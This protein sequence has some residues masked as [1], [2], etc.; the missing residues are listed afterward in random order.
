MTEI[1]EIPI[2]VARAWSTRLPARGVRLISI[3]D[4]VFRTASLLGLCCP[5]LPYSLVWLSVKGARI[6]RFWLC[7]KKNLSVIACLQQLD[8]S[9]REQAEFSLGIEHGWRLGGP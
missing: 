8:H 7:A 9:R 3:L 1:Y 5:G 2:E 6:A 4:S